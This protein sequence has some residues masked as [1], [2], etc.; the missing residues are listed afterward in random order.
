MTACE[1]ELLRVE[2][3]WRCAQGHSFDVARSGY[4]NLLRPNDRRSAEPGDSRAAVEARF[5]LENLGVGAAQA[6]ALTRFVAEHRPSGSAPV[7]DVGAGTGM[8]LERLREALAGEACA[9]DLST[10]ACDLGARKRPA[11]RWIVANA[12]RVLPFF[13]ASFG[14]I[15][16]SVGP[17][18]PS[19]MRRLLADDGRLVL[20]V[21]GADDLVELRTA[22]RSTG[23]LQDR[24]PAT[25]QRFDPWFTCA[26]HETVRTRMR[27][28]PSELLDLLASTYRGARASERGRAL[29]LGAMDV[30][31][32]A[33]LLLLA[34][35]AVAPS[36]RV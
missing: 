4:V 25:L 29:A 33:E 36:P 32:S 5:R 12:D 30:T 24:V 10:R 26:A 15:L 14:L 7:L 31:F 19:E 34:P 22:V 35:R 1:R 20:V 3:T 6:E 2:R 13:D 8:Q 9:V 21:S 18:H 28:G 27:L 23:A 16:S 17:K 11:L